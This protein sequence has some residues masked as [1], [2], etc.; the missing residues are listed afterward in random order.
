MGAIQLRCIALLCI[1]GVVLSEQNEDPIDVVVLLDSSDSFRS[2]H[3]NSERDFA[4]KIVR[5]LW[6]NNNRLSF[7]TF[8]DS[9]HRQFSLDTYHQLTDLT[10][11]I[12]YMWFSTGNGNV[13]EALEFTLDNA[14]TDVAGNRDC[15]PNVLIVLSHTGIANATVAALIKQKLIHESVNIIIIDMV[16]GA[17]DHGFSDIV[18]NTSKILV[19]PDFQTLQSIHSKVF[20]QVYSDHFPTGCGT[21]GDWQPWTRCSASC[22]SGLRFRVRTCYKARDTDK[23]CFGERSQDEECRSG[24]CLDPLDGGWSNW[25]R[26]S[27]CSKTCNKG[28]QTRQRLC[29]EP[30][31]INGGKPCPGSANQTRD[32]A[33]WKC[34]DCSKPCPPGGHLSGDCAICECSSV[35][36]FGR[37][38]DTFNSPIKD[39]KVFLSSTLYRPGAKTDELGYFDI[40]GVCLMNETV[41]IEKKGHS[42][43]QINPTEVNAT[44][45]IVNASLSVNVAPVFNASPE[46]KIRL[47]GQSVSLCCSAVGTPPPSSYIWFKDE[48]EIENTGTNGKLELKSLSQL[49]SGRYKCS[50]E[51]DAGVSQSEE[52]VLTIK[53]KVSDTCDGPISKL[54]VLP[55]TCFV[56]GDPSRNSTIDTKTCG[57]GKC[58]S[59]LQIDNGTCTDWWPHHCCDVGETELVNISCDGFNY[60]ANRI[61]TCK[62]QKCISKTTI[63]GRA[64]GRLNGSV[65]PLQLGSVYANGQLVSRTSMAGYFRFDV[66]KSSKMI[67]LHFSD[68]V[69]KKLLDHTKTVNAIEGADTQVS[70]AIPIKPKPISFNPNLGADIQLGS[71]SNAKQPSSSISI[72]DNSLIT[73][74]GQPYK[75]QAKA[76]VHFMDPRNREDMET[77]NGEFVFESPNGDK[78]PLQTYGMF[79]VTLEDHNGNSL[80]SNKP[81]RFSLD[82][83]MFNI[84]LDENGNPDLAM[85]YYDVN[86]GVWVEQGKMQF[87]SAV[88][89][90]RKLLD[91]V[92][93]GDFTPVEIPHMDP[94]NYHTERKI[95]G[96]TNCDKSVPIYKDVQVRDAPKSGACF[97]SVSAYKDFTLQEPADGGSV[98]VTAY[99]QEFDGSAYLGTETRSVDDKGHV[100][101]MTFCDKFVY[102]SAE[103]DGQKLLPAMHLLPDFY[104]VHN[105]SSNKEVKFESRYFGAAYDCQNTSPCLGPMYTFANGG[106]SKCKSTSDSSFKFRFAPFTKEPS[107]SLT[108]GSKNVY[109]KKLSWYPVSPDKNTFRSCF[110]K[111]QVKVQGAFDLRVVAKSHLA[112]ANGEEFGIHNVGPVPSPKTADMSNR[113]ACLEFRCAGFVRDGLKEVYDQPTVVT[114]RL[115]SSD[116]LLKCNMSYQSGLKVT[117]AADEKGF[118]FVAEAGNNYGSVF[119]VFIN[120][121]DAS[122]VKDFCYSGMDTGPSVDGLMNPD[123]NPAI[124]YD[125]R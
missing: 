61:K 4:D 2:T 108:E 106:Q 55:P 19:S 62:C 20:D 83:S 17:G 58:I 51:T 67:I 43:D 73:K 34:P 75:G 28:I 45:W 116:S 8:G 65:V 49:D 37:V 76:A 48:I 90:R 84:S 6:R 107:M 70:V 115:V 25:G 44:H 57:N 100:C 21:L 78:L 119:G 63:S 99:S 117:K 69:F 24:R 120:D 104:P 15:T 112:T 121:A 7:Y 123:S 103:K 9:I 93:V 33:G 32:C 23:D 105:S 101:L 53:G 42:S 59:S 30:L 92:I 35:T 86:K 11:A 94:Y 91:T 54:E 27:G 111:V 5:L 41:Y 85:W 81:F 52:A 89:G 12:G 74:D 26:W 98:K 68:E 124:V 47:L 109:D 96:Y 36:L 110:I 16:R 88:G 39:A 3:F 95:V 102:L 13:E 87:S 114:G 31:P 80:Q 46:S 66:P 60:Q 72:P 77:A 1:F 38:T 82:S 79:H 29:N 118:T 97:V 50:A 125:C 14:F 18:K 71:N 10:A 122:H 56:S 40:S 64:F 22:G 113:A